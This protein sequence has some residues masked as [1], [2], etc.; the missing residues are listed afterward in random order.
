MFRPV[1][2]VN[3]VI[4]T[5]FNHESNIPHVLVCHCQHASISYGCVMGFEEFSLVK[6]CP[7]KVN[8]NAPVGWSPKL[9]FKVWTSHFLQP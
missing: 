6:V 4:E 5:S 7:W 2:G 9:Q 8:G 3:I 1:N